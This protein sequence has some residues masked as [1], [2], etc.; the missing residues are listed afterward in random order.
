MAGFL[1]AY[2]PAAGP[3]PTRQRTTRVID[4]TDPDDLSNSVVSAA[5]SLSVVEATPKKKPKITDA[6]ATAQSYKMHLGKATKKIENIQKTTKELANAAQELGNK[7]TAASRR[8]F[9]VAVKRVQ[10]AAGTSQK[11]KG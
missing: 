1:E 6:A 5:S 11:E 8:D 2:M 4:L 7:N 10:A 3:A 9:K